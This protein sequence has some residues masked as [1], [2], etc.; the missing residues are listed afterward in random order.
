[1]PLRGARRWYLVGGLRGSGPCFPHFYLGALFA[2][3]LGMKVSST[4]S[5]LVCLEDVH[6]SFKGVANG[7]RLRV[8]EGIDLAV[9]AS[10]VLAILGP[11]GCG[12]S[13]LLRVAS[14]LLHPDQGT[15]RWR[16]GLLADRGAK[17][18]MNFQ[19]PVLLPWL[20]LEE[21]AL[22]PFRLRLGPRG[23]VSPEIERKLESLLDFTGLRR[24][25]NSLPH[26]LS[27]G[28]Q[29]RAALIRS[30]ITDPELI[31]LDEPFAA[32]D[33]I[34]RQDLGR[35]FRLSIEMSKAATI[36]VTHSIQ[37]AA[38]L[39]DRIVILSPRP[40]RVVESV[41]IHYDRG[42]RDDGLRRSKEFLDL[43]DHLREVMAHG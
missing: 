32:I 31:F 21:N 19:K 33:E 13:S 38:F 1:M 7:P 42:Q 40:A 6:L 22:L 17:M 34:T 29:M 25:R 30:L 35:E 10:E 41:K 16:D 39:A 4:S 12:K 9:D 11:S 43:C 27:G 8:L 14:G 36:F 20:S 23:R 5:P 15:V 26:E 18:A 28:M 37:E 24:F 2:E 3:L